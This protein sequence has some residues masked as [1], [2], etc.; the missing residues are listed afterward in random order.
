VRAIVIDLNQQGSRS[1]RALRTAEFAVD[2]LVELEDAIGLAEV[3][4]IDLIVVEATASASLAALVRRIRRDGVTAPLLVRLAVHD[5]D[6]VTACLEE[7]AD[8]CI[9]HAAADME[10]RARATS[11]VR[12]A[13]SLAASIIDLGGLHVDLVRKCATAGD[14]HLPLTRTEYALLEAL[15]LRR[16]HVLDR[17]VLTD[18]L[19]DGDQEPHPKIVDVFICKLRQKLRAATGGEIIRTEWGRGYFLPSRRAA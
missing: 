2:H 11:L 9:W 3:A 1:V 7:G 6:V 8:D 17:S 18:L 14:F 19:Y 10:I 5:G 4:T 15:C 16:G 12:R 13:R